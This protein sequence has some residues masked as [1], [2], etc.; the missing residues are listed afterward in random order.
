MKI[1]GRKLSSKALEEIRKKAVIKVQSGQSPSQVAK[2]LSIYTCRIFEWLSLY[3]SGGEE[4]LQV[5]KGKGGGRPRTLSARQIKFIYNAIASKNPEQFKFKFALWTRRQVQELIKR[6]YGIE[7]SLPSIGR[8]LRELG[9]SWQKPL[10]KAYEQDPKE[11]E[12]WLKYKFSY[13]KRRARKEGAEIFFSDE[14]GLRSDHQA[15]KTWGKRGQTPVVKK[16]GKR[17][18]LNMISAISS[19][20]EIRFQVI[21]GRFNSDRF[22]KFCKRLISTS[23]K[24]VFLI[25]DGHPAHKSKKVKKFIKSL[26]GKL[27]LYYLPPYSPELNPDELVW[28]DLKT[29]SIYR[30]SI[31]TKEEL[32]RAVVSHFRH[33]QK[34]PWKIRAFF[35]AVRTKYAI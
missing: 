14:S 24:K 21:E 3:R 8:L 20:G 9:F 12:K 7:L 30:K 11:V 2:D 26:K 5:R 23:E 4:A 10:Q 13:I 6:K 27:S 29:N 22:I 32:K 25:V 18:G 33:L 17:F 16:T 1:D 15:G 31:K 28:N 35:Q 19:R 34:C